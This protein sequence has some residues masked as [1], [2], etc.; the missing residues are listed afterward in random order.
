MTGTPD[1]V[2][3][4]TAI[5]IPHT[6]EDLEAFLAD[7]DR[8][9]ISIT[10]DP[11]GAARLWHERLKQNPYGGEG[12]VTVE[13]FGAELMG[14][15][16]IDWVTVTWDALV[17]AVEEFIGGEPGTEPEDRRP[18]AP[19]LRRV[20]AGALFSVEDRTV[21]VDPEVIIPGLL[22][23]AA[24]FSGWVRDQLGTRDAPELERIDRLR[25]AWEQARHA[26]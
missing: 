16:R 10:E 9:L 15:E 5:L 8:A 19:A 21:L 4:D 20:P 13:Y 23:G 24:A 25:T 14:P 1:A 6:V 2:R 18:E 3:C 7:P 17:D 26:R 12:V 11:S 22:D